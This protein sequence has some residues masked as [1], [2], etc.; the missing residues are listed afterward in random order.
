[1][2]MGMMRSWAHFLLRKK[3]GFPGVPPLMRPLRAPPIPCAVST[4]GK[5]EVSLIFMY[6]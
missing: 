5:P 6:I 2:M 3:P 4:S 1:M